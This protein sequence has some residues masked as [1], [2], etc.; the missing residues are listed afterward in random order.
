MDSERYNR[1]AV[2][3][4][5]SPVNYGGKD[6]RRKLCIC[7]CGTFKVVRYPD[8]RNGKSQSCGCYCVEVGKSGG[9]GYATT[10][11]KSSSQVYNIWTLMVQRCTNEKCN[12]YE[13]YG[14]RGVTV[15][16][17][18]LES[19]E[20]FYEDMG[21]KP[22][23]YSL[24]RID[25]EKGYSKNNCKWSTRHE[26][27]INTRKYKSNSSGRTGVYLNKSNG[28]WFSQIQSHGVSYRSKD[29]PKF[30]DAVAAR[31][32]LELTHHGRIRSSDYEKERV[33]T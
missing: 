18:W 8:L 20:K 13:N 28:M 1:W 33:N 27:S 22:D 24:D 15:C 16:Q 6:T 4:E 19:F 26:Q 17:Q 7:D 5:W 9:V 2:L 32:L 25:N 23:G 10:H 21:D 11:G 30:E 12:G 31:E 14:G 29:F 3:C